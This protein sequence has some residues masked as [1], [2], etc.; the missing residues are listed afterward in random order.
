[1]QL[2]NCN[3]SEVVEGT[4]DESKNEYSPL[5]YEDSIITFTEENLIQPSHEEDTVDLFGLES[6]IC[7]YMMFYLQKEFPG[8]SYIKY[9]N[10]EEKQTSCTNSDDCS[11]KVILSLSHRSFPKYDDEL[12]ISG[13]SSDVDN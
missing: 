10:L 8:F 3:T 5:L 1:M 11:S 7:I 6:N 12:I 2:K 4:Y 9:D 13:L